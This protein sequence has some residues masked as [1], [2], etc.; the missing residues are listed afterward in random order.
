MSHEHFPNTPYSYHYI[1]A[2]SHR[3]ALEVL[4]IQQA[5]IGSSQRDEPYTVSSAVCKKC[6]GKDE[7]LDIQQNMILHLQHI[8]A[9]E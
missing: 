2:D 5:T 4:E 7:L 3:E 6:K 1:S 9:G 8:A